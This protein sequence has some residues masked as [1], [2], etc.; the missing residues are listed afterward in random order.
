VAP[1]PDD[2]NDEGWVKVPLMWIQRKKNANK[3]V[4]SLLTA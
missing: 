3:G 1:E 4:S 2:D